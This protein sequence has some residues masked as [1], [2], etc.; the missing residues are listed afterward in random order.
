MGIG[1]AAQE[2]GC[3][4]RGS[5]CAN[6]EHWFLAVISG[7]GVRSSTPSDPASSFNSSL[8]L[9]NL[10][11][12]VAIVGILGLEPDLVANLDLLKHCGIL[13]AIGHGH[14]LVHPEALGG[15]V[16]ERDLSPALIDL[17]DFAVERALRT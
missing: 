8:A 6:F 1:N 13:H 7:S 3:R 16:L 2:D 15:T 4:Q 14:A 17:L 5:E 10:R 9:L 11:D 12:R